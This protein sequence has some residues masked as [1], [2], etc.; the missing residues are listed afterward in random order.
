[1]S[2]PRT[3][4]P[5][6]IADARFM[7]P[8]DVDMVLKL[9]TSTKSLITVEEGSIGGFGSHVM[10]TLSD[11]GM[12]DGGLRMRAMMLPDEFI[13]HDSPT[14]CMPSPAST[15]RASSPRCSSARQGLQDRDGQARLRSAAFRKLPRPDPGGTGRAG[16]RVKKR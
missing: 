9:A 3:A 11:H 15:P 10:Q 12:L 8:L 13:D 5:P 2:S 1:M 7:K 16:K 4:C 14:R 6:P